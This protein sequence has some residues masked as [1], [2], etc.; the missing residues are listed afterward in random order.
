MPIQAVVEALSFA[1]LI[2]VELPLMHVEL[3]LMLPPIAV[4][5]LIPSLVL[6]PCLAKL[7]VLLLLDALILLDSLPPVVASILILTLVVSPSLV[8][9]TIFV[10]LDALLLQ[11]SLP[12]VLPLYSLPRVAPIRCFASALRAVAFEAYVLVLRRR[13]FASSWSHDSFERWPSYPQTFFSLALR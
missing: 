3:P 13:S 6:L 11:A 2:D 1:I 9:L 7:A 8:E 12:L 10:L 5:L 4:C